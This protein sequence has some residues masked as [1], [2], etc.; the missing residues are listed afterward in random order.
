MED[1][2]SPGELAEHLL[3][4]D[5]NP[6]AYLAHFWW[7]DHYRAVWSKGRKS[8]AF[9]ELCRKLHAPHEPAKVLRDVERWWWRQSKCVKRGRNP[10]SNSTT[11]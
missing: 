4:L 1:F 3:R 5:S 8:A 6:E 2:S 7:K 10:W 9:C 11:V